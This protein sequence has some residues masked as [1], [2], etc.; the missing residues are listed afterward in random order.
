MDEKN[1]LILT[2]ENRLVFLGE[3][4]ISRAVRKQ[5]EEPMGYGR[6]RAEEKDLFLFLF[7]KMERVQKEERHAAERAGGVLLPAEGTAVLAG[8]LGAPGAVSLLKTETALEAREQQEQKG[9][10]DGGT[11]EE[12]LLHTVFCGQSLRIV[13]NPGKEAYGMQNYQICFG[14]QK[15]NV[16]S[17]ADF[18]L[19]LLRDGCIRYFRTENPQTR[20]NSAAQVLEGKPFDAFW[21]AERMKKD[22]P[23]AETVLEP[24]LAE[25]LCGAEKNTGSFYLSLQGTGQYVRPIRDAGDPRDFRTAW[26]IFSEEEML[27]RIRH[28]SHIYARMRQEEAQMKMK[29]G[30]SFGLWGSD[31][32]IDRIRYLL[33]KGA[34]TNT[35][36]LLTGESGTGKTFLA[37]EIHKCSRRSGRPFVHVNCAAIPYN[38]LESELFGYEEGAFTGARKGGRAGYFQMADQGTLFLDEITELPL[39]LQGKLLEVLQNRTY[40]PV[41]AEKKKRADVRLIAATN[42]DLQELVEQKLFREDLYYRINVFP[43]ELPPLRERLDSLLSV[44]SDLLPEI[45]SRLEIGP[46]IV[47]P[48]AL[49]KMRQYPWPGNIREL[50]NVLEK[51]CILSDGKIIQPEDIELN[52]QPQQT[53]GHGK[54]LKTQRENFEKR[55]IEKTLKAC[56]GSRLKTAQYLEIGKTSLFE[57]MKKYGIEEKEREDDTYDYD[58]ND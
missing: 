21:D 18:A 41:G 48:Q 52:I 40:F 54:S 25:K 53:P 37:K 2:E 46:Q 4:L 49:E 38:L 26:Q 14:R 10:T 15:I 39:P 30:Y 34:A 16:S 45:C 50:E 11:A 23:P 19:I 6:G 5:M 51:A 22:S 13:R 55:V 32:K 36:I 44:I 8:V 9:E 31:P 27:Q 1:I 24:A 12:I 7:P 29:G 42:K 3:N 47:S 58:S 57:K 20:K 43:V 35:T 33:Q 56:G 28:D 17:D